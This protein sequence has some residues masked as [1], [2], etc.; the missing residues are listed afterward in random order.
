L[1][2]VSVD[3]LSMTGRTQ[4]FSLGE[5]FA[6]HYGFDLIDKKKV[7]TIEYAGRLL[8]IAGLTVDQDRV[9]ETARWFATGL[10]GVNVS[11]YT[12][13]H[14]ISEDSGV[15]INRETS[16]CRRRREKSLTIQRLS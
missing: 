14:G 2:K 10:W 8:M 13:F 9:E 11:S 12:K 15:Q 4:A 6:E 1:H 7:Y 3:S 16:D 5:S